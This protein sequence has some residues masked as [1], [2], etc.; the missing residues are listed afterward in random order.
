MIVCVCPA[1]VIVRHFVIVNVAVQSVPVPAG[2]KMV[3]LVDAAAMQAESSLCW[4]LAAVH[5]VAPG[6]GVH[7]AHD[8]SVRM[9]TRIQ[10]H[11]AQRTM[12]RTIIAL[13]Q[14]VIVCSTQYFHPHRLP[15]VAAPQC[16]SRSWRK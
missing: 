12:N 15:V 2:T 3:S 14:S 1:P 5:S 8:A 6:P 7:A 11:I 13:P 10:D 9:V 16:N 4:A